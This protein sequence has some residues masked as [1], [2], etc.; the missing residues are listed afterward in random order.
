[1]ENIQQSII[2]APQPF[3]FAECYR[4]LARSPNEVLH[5]TENGKI[6]K[7]LKLNNSLVL[8]EL[9]EIDQ[10]KIKINI[11]NQP[12]DR[13][14]FLEIEK[15]VNLWLDFNT[16]LGGFYQIAEG[17]LLLKPLTNKYHG[18]RLIGM[19]DLFEA[20]CWA[21]IG[22]QINL[23]FAY[24]LKKRWVESFGECLGFEGKKYYLHPDYKM[25]REDLY[26]ELLKI[27]F[28]RQKAK[29]VIEVAKAFQ[30]GALSIENLKLQSFEEAKISLCKIKGIGN[31]TANYVLM[32]SLKYKEAF[33][34]EDV[35]LHNAL[36]NELKLSQKPTLQEIRT[37]AEQWKG[38]EAYATFYLWRSLLDTNHST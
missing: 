1:M 37:M 7:L 18:L 19:N 24:T 33:P 27:Q 35:G 31:W 22:Q 13:N 14:T 25:V 16:D 26:E 28:S 21:I 30:S 20:L 17:D 5:Q 32:K 9:E 3:S 11:L 8:F 2:Q 4:F 38:W 6:Y 34:I 10:Q 29:Y 23:N 36:K 15:Y 12:Y